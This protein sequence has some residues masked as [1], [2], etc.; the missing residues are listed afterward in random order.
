MKNDNS[1]LDLNELPTCEGYLSISQHIYQIVS[2]MLEIY[3]PKA[4]EVFICK[5]DEELGENVLY[6][7]IN[8]DKVMKN[9]KKMQ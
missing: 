9:K 2:R 6:N 5:G 3:I 8:Q 4:T 1:W 7:S